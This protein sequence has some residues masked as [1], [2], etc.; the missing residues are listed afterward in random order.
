MQNKAQPTNG[1]FPPASDPA[2]RQENARFH[3][4]MF[5]TQL[6]LARWQNG[7]AVLQVQAGAPALRAAWYAT[8]ER[9]FQAWLDRGGFCQHDELLPLIPPSPPN[10]AFWVA[11]RAG[12]LQQLGACAG[13]AP[14]LGE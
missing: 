11:P 13:A 8:A 1:T 14:T 10:P 7:S 6:A 3:A 2:E 5:S 12:G 9:D 4:A